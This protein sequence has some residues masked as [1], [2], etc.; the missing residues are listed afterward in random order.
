MKNYVQPGERIAFTAGADVASGGVVVIGTLV[1]VSVGA[2]A[3][4][5]Q[6]QAVIE[7]VFSLP[8]LTGVLTAGAVVYWNAAGPGVTTSST[9]NTRAGVVIAAAT[10]AA[11]TALVKLNV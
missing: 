2:V 1:G 5:A 4:G 3:N 10:T 9:G 7:G 8:K 6:G 11:T